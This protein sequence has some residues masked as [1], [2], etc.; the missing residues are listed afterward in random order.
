MIT[1]LI[2]REKLIKLGIESSKMRYKRSIDP[3]F[4]KKNNKKN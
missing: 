3:V 1:W 4:E 2:Y